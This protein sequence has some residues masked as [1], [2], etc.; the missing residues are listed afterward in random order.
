MPS[1]NDDKPT[2]LGCAAMFAA[3]LTFYRWYVL[4][5]NKKLDSGD[6]EKIASVIRGGVTQEMIDLGWRYEMF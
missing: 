4:N 5:E 2:V 6:P 1:A 3:T